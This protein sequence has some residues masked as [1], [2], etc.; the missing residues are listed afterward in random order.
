MEGFSLNRLTAYLLDKL[1]ESKTK[2]VYIILLMF[3][4]F[5]DGDVPGWAKNI[6]FGAFGYLLSPI[7]SIPDL[8]PIIGMTDDISVLS[9][10]LVTIA[11]YIN[12]EVRLK[13][14]N[15]MDDY[16][17]TKVEQK[18]ITEVDSWL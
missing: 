18:Y 4:A 10:A 6:I 14:R 17:G 12:D 8:T 9:F 11:C 16:L 13:A 2:S 5:K 15:K 7:D 3:Y 1:R